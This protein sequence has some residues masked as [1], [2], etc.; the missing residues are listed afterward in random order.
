MHKR[1]IG[2][3]TLSAVLAAALVACG[4]GDGG[5]EISID[6]DQTLAVWGWSGAP[7]ADTMAKVIDAFESEHPH[8]TVE[9]NEITNT[10]YANRATLG[11]SSEQDID[12]LAVFPNALTSELA[13][14]LVPVSEWDGGDDIIG[15]LQ[16]QALAQAEKLSGDDGLRTVPMNSNGSAVGFYNVDL[17]EQAGF[18][19]PPKTWAEMKQFTDAL[20]GVAP[21]VVPAVIASD[22]W[23]QNDFLMTLVGQEDPDLWN[24]VLYDEAEF[25]SPALRDALA[26]YHQIYADGTLDRSTLD[27]QYA[28][29]MSAFGEGNAAIVFTGTWESG[30]LLAEYREANGVQATDVGVMAVPGNDPA[31]LG[32]RAFLDTTYA[33]P[34]RSNQKAAAAAFIEFITVGAGVDVWGPTLVGVPAVDGWS[35]PEGVLT[36]DVEQASYELIQELIANPRGDRTGA[37]AFQ[38][39]VGTYALQVASGTMTPDAAAEQAQADLSSGTYN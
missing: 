13:G 10:D 27:I 25:D 15:G 26:T 29:A 1:R 12:V 22:S 37:D 19:E 21:D 28:D 5:E 16:P 17:F 11:L 24:S 35:L 6:A 3:P 18:N 33:I 39:Q 9:Y 2:L 8:I 36:T 38:N 23:F 7:G 32:L 4:G 20:A 30:L 14:Y 34:E 31:D